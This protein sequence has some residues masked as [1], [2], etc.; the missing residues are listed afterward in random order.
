M[1]SLHV[2]SAVL[3]ALACG[4]LNRRLAT[5]MWANAALIWLGSVHLAWHYA[6]DG[7]LGG[8]IAL[9]AWKTAD[10]ALAERLPTRASVAA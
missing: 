10:V 4:R 6:I 5:A 9:A 8:A 2:A 7:V 3:L 1:P